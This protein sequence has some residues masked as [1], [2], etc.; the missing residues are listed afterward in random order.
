MKLSILITTTLNRRPLFRVLY[1][2]LLRQ[3][4]GLE[5]EV[6]YE[7]DDKKISVG[8][9][10][11][12]LLNRAKGSHL[13]Y[14]DSDDFPYEW[15]VSDI[16]KALESDPDCVGFLIH[17]TTNNRKPQTCCHSLQY[18]EWKENV[19]GYD[20]VRNNTH[21]NPTRRSIALQVG[22]KDLRH[23]E[24]KAY[25]DAVSKI[26]KTEF[27]INKRLFHYRYSNAEPHRKK[28]GFK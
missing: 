24:D 19:D 21:F 12:I 17:M 16:L 26:C 3:S 10:R 5:V 8:A 6:L 11:Q 4:S 9:K 22:F 23:G 15:Y 27:F 20:Y 25:S 1:A 13:C 7:E 28:Y 14:F 2:E 18:P